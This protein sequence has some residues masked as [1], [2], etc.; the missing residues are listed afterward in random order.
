M[1]MNGQRHATL[2]PGEGATRGWVG[3]EP[4]EC[5]GE[6]KNLSHVANRTRVVQ[7]VH[8]MNVIYGLLKL[9]RAQPQENM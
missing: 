2:Y 5:G 4:S 8:Y 6:E 9:N 7:S 1:E 3:P